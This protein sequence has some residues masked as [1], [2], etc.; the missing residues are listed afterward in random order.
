MRRL[1]VAAAMFL[2]LDSGAVYESLR[3]ETYCETLPY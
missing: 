3:E 1:P 2:L